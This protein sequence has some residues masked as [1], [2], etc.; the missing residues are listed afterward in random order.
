MFRVC[1][2]IRAERTQHS[3]EGAT[4]NSP[5]EAEFID[6][7]RKMAANEGA[8]VARPHITPGQLAGQVNPEILLSSALSVGGFVVGAHIDAILSVKSLTN[9]LCFQSAG[10]H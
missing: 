10:R 5:T 4:L 3:T 9:L 2:A 1:E 7:W 6:H 8:H